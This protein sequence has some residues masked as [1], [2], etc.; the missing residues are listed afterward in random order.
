MSI[1]LIYV[2]IV[3]CGEGRGRCMSMRERTH[4]AVGVYQWCMRSMDFIREE[5]SK[6]ARYMFAAAQ[7][8]YRCPAH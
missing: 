7:L 2:F 1:P 5:K 4:L 3:K 8:T 6:I